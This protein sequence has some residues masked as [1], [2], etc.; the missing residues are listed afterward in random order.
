M[1][2][3]KR[4]PAAVVL[5]SAMVLGSLVMRD[6]GLSAED[7]VTELTEYAATE[8]ALAADLDYR[9][10]IYAQNGVSGW[11]EATGTGR[12]GE[13]SEI[14][15][16][17]AEAL[18]RLTV[19]PVAAEALVDQE[20]S[21]SSEVVAALPENVI[22]Q[23][24]ETLPTEQDHIHAPKE[25]QESVEQAEVPASSRSV[26]EEL[27]SA[28]AE[29]VDW[30]AVA[31][32]ESGGD[33]TINTGNGYYGLVQFDEGT[34]LSNGG[35]DFAPRADLASY[36]QQITIAKILYSRRGPSP[37]PGCMEMLGYL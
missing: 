24:T 14:G 37:W 8:P 5:G 32:C 22:L 31:K 28:S 3:F 18:S 9:Q 27:I 4:G 15:L 20:S 36:D 6:T 12:S 21:V 34:W 19:T 16:L 26:S 23:P 1:F 13:V 30:A 10:E 11:P 33:P 35:G 25:K 7:S 29:D 17:V 2:E